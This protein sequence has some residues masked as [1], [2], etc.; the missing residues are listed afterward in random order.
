MTLTPEQFNLIAT[1]EEFNELKSEIQEIK[2]DIKH[3]VT[4][5]DSVVYELKSMNS[6]LTANI[7]AYDRFETRITKIEK[8]LDFKPAF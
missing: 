1:K 3:L 7:G 4:A 2:G 8:H 5:V 6:D